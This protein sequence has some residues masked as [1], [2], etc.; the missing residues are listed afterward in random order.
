[1][2]LAQGFAI[3]AALALVLTGRASPRQRAADPIIQK[4]SGPIQG[5]VRNGI[6]QFLGIP[7]AAPPVGALR[8]RPPT[9]GQP[10]SAP[11]RARAFRSN[12]P[13]NQTAGAF[14]GPPGTTEDCLYLNV[15]APPA[16]AGQKAPVMVFI[17]GG[18]N[19]TGSGN[20]YDA[21]ALVTQGHVIV[22]TFN[23]RLGLLGFLAHPALDNEDPL[24]GNYGL[25]DQQAVLSWVQTNSAAFGGDPDNITLF[26]QSAGSF[27][28][29]AHLLSPRVRG[30]FQR[31]ILMSGP[32]INPVTATLSDAR[33]R[34]ANFAQ[35]AGC[36]SARPEQISSC[37]RKLPVER[38][39]AMQGSPS[40]YYPNPH[41][42]DVG[43]EIIVDG[44]IIPLM[45]DDAW[46]SGRFNRMP[47]MIGIT[48][49][50][51]AFDLMSRAALGEP[52]LTQSQ[53][54][55]EIIGQFGAEAAKRVLARYPAN[56]YASPSEAFIAATSGPIVCMARHVASQL[57]E[58]T[59]VYAYEFADRTAPSYYPEVSF[60]T[61]AYHTAELQYLFPGYHGGPIGIA[62]N[63]NA[64]Q[65]ALA[66]QMIQLW[67]SFA[68][69][70][71]PN[72]VKPV[73]RWRPLARDN[74]TYLQLEAAGS[75]TVS[76]RDYV[77]R[78]G[79]NLWDELVSY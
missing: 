20:D 29:A 15:F 62:R 74:I 10:W 32:L 46:K 70:G 76:D 43:K 68:T 54:E 63:L 53:V 41:Y 40:Q 18:G 24:F 72:S 3:L 44:N 66:S 71:D 5:I 21:S 65:Q 26:G 61:R 48:R 50:E 52:S 39:L 45:P 55:K 69:T 79:C 27:D 19:F 6:S 77:S 1:M 4:A 31:A 35:D 51:Q 9:P 25:L 22:V 73:Q 75:T 57:S 33:S 60:P 23:Y 56:R 17:H 47:V 34:G 67:T 28:V 11:L 16:A 78:F 59:S 12:C 2:S 64:H 58:H 13:T 8:W 37:L 30:R 38:I 14:A 49:D 36:G 42:Y 7:Y